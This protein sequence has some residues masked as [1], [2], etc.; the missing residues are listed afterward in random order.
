MRFIFLSSFALLFFAAPAGAEPDLN[1]VESPHSVNDTM[2]RLFDVV[3]ELL[4]AAI[5]C[6]AAFVAALR[7]F[8]W[9]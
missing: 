2:E 8:R 9:T 6:V 3:T 7:V 4:I 1:R 5:W